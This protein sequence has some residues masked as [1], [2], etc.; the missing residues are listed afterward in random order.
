L[1]TTHS[2]AIRSQFSSLTETVGTGTLTFTFGTTG[3]TAH[4]SDNASDAYDGFVAKAGVASKT[5]TIDGTNNTLA[6]LRDAINE[7]DI[8]VSAAIV[9][10]GSAYRLLLSS[11]ASG[12]ENSMRYP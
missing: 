11:G 8:G 7:A 1:A 6:G 12:A 2:V 5:V 9:N 3:Y 4:A 10:Q